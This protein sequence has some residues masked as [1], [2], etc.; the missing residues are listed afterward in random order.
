ML[1]HLTRNQRASILVPELTKI[2]EDFDGALPKSLATAIRA[3]QTLNAL[4]VEQPPPSNAGTTLLAAEHLVSHAGTGKPDLTAAAAPLV[5]AD[6]DRRR[7]EIHTQVL[8]AAR[9]KAASHVLG[10]AYTAATALVTDVIR[11]A[12]LK[13]L[14][15]IDANA[16]VLPRQL[17]DAGALPEQL[18]DVAATQPIDVQKR[19]SE[20]SKATAT[21]LRGVDARA[22]MRAE[23]LLPT[24]AVDDNET[25]ALCRN[26]QQLTDDPRTLRGDYRY[27]ELPPKDARLALLRMSRKGASWWF[28][29]TAEQD[30][31]AAAAFDDIKASILAIQGGRL[32]PTHGIA[33]TV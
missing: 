23:Q 24:L 15:V 16:G 3:W 6:H 18:D 17:D 11:P 13:A 28:P 32:R 30:Q 9:D 2:V 26:P 12:V 27:T 7:A 20:V 21:V 4:E 25:F 10:S 19:W 5:D 33:V 8:A 22:Y 31:T 1:D 14:A 29:L